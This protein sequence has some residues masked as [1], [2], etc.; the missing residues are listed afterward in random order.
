MHVKFFKEKIVENSGY[1]LFNW[2]DWNSLTKYFVI[3]EKIRAIDY[4]RVKL[5]DKKLISSE[6]ELPFDK[7]TEMI[8][9]PVK[10]NI[11]KVK[12]QANE[13]EKLIYANSKQSSTLAVQ[14]KI[15]HDQKTPK[16]LPLVNSMKK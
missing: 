3:P 2:N 6:I 13:F 10:I 16:S 9:M 7:D 12:Q 11:E 4:E 14:T 8:E 15:V 1:M 5:K